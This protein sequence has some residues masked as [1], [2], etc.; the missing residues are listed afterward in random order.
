MGKNRSSSASDTSRGGKPDYVTPEYIAAQRAKR[1][2]AKQEKLKRNA[3]LGVTPSE[4]FDLKFIK[5]PM[6]DVG[7]AQSPVSKSTD[8]KI[9]TYNV[10]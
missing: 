6:L 2:L 9:M 3:E 7:L 4:E 1:E 8:I 5:R 10:R